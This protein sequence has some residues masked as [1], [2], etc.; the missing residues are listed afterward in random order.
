MKKA[1]LMAVC[2]LAFA[3]TYSYGRD[4]IQLSASTEWVEVVVENTGRRAMLLEHFISQTSGLPFVMECEF[5]PLVDGARVRTRRTPLILGANESDST[6]GI[7]LIRIPPG[8][9]LQYRV[10][11]AIFDS[12]V[13]NLA[14]ENYSAKRDF[15]VRFAIRLELVSSRGHRFEVRRTSGW[16]HWTLR[17][18]WSQ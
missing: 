11:L 1:L 12:S 3:G 16:L 6:G 9:R 18:G 13:R 8:A 10:P 5:G 14:W 7:P 15:T 4:N 2:L 17:S